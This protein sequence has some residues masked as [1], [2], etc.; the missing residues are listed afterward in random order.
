MTSYV[1]EYN[2]VYYQNSPIGQYWLFLQKCC[3]LKTKTK[4]TNKKKHL[5][6][7]ITTIYKID[8]DLPFF[9]YLHFIYKHKEEDGKV[10]KWTPTKCCLCLWQMRLLLLL[11]AE[12]VLFPLKQLCTRCPSGG[13]T[14]CWNLLWTSIKLTKLSWV[15]ISL[16]FLLPLS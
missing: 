10:W 7:L 2:R 12:F 15:G 1:S 9:L 16:S 11:N 6:L 13:H 4:Q 14:Q 5:V 3:Q 8:L